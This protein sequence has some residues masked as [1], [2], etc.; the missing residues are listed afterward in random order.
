[1]DGVIVLNEYVNELYI[2]QPWMSIFLLC[3]ILTFL[4][5][6]VL[7][8]SKHRL[9]DIASVCI[10]IISCISAF[11]I[12]VLAPTNTETRYQVFIDDSVSF[13]EFCEQYEIIEINGKI[14]T[15]R[16]LDK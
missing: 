6:I 12:S 2:A 14:Y 5:I 4:F 1:M 9:L 13:N 15:V 8:I 3:I 10:C 11:A 16:P 7:K